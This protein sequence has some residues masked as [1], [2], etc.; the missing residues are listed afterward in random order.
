MVLVTLGIGMSI[1]S[2]TAPASYSTWRKISV[3]EVRGQL[4]AAAVLCMGLFGAGFGPLAVALVTNYVVGDEA[5]LGLS[6]SIV[7]GTAA[8]LMGLVFLTGRRSLSAI[9]D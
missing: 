7:L 9:P 8:P 5:R 1:M 4:S 3:P 6:L 2:V